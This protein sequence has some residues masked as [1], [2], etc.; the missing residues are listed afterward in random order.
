METCKIY[1]LN[2][3]KTL[4]A[5][6]LATSEE[7][8]RVASL[9]TS[10]ENFIEAVYFLGLILRHCNSDGHVCLNV[11]DM[12][13]LILDILKK[14]LLN[15]E[16][17]TKEENREL[18]EEL[19][20]FLT[21]KK[22]TKKNFFSKY[23][24]L[25]AIYNNTELSKN[26][27]LDTLLSN[28]EDPSFLEG[29]KETK[30]FEI[31]L[32]AKLNDPLFNVN[33][34]KCPIVF[35]HK[36]FYFARNFYSEYLISED[37]K[38]IKNYD[39]LTSEIPKFSDNL[40]TNDEPSK[41]LISKIIKVNNLDGS[42]GSIIK[43]NLN[44]LKS[45]ISYF[46]D[47]ENN[48]K[49]KDEINWQKN[50]VIISLLHSISVITGGPG[51][52]KTTSVAKLITILMLI[53][54]DLKI[55]LAAPT[56]K[57]ADR[58][59]KAFIG[60]IDSTIKEIFDKNEIF[61]SIKDE[62]LLKLRDINSSTLH[63]LIGVIINKNDA[64]YNKEHPLPY[65]YL[66]IDEASMIDLALMQKT[67]DSIDFNRTK[68]I[69]LGDKDQLSSVEAGAILGD[70]CSVFNFKVKEL[71]PRV[72]EKMDIDIEAL[73]YISQINDKSKLL[74]SFKT[75]KPG[76]EEIYIAPGISSLLHSYRFTSNKG[77]GLV[78]SLINSSKGE[79]LRDYL[80]KGKSKYPSDDPT[81][82]DFY[83]VDTSID[84]NLR[85]DN[86]Y[87][88]N[89]RLDK[90]FD[91]NFKG[92]KE[93]K[94]DNYFEYLNLIIDSTIKDGEKFIFNPNSSNSSLNDNE[95][96]FEV[97]KN[98]FTSFNKFR[99]LVP[100]NEGVYGVN[101]INEYIQNLM[102]EIIKQNP[103]FKGMGQD[104]DLQWLPGLPYIVTKNDNSLGIYNGDIGICHFD[105]KGNQSHRIWFENG[106]SFP[107]SLLSNIEPAFAMTIHKSQGSEFNH[108]EVI[109]SQGAQR[110]LSKEL[111]YTAVTRAKEQLTIYGE[112]DLITKGKALEGVKRFS[113]LKE[114]LYLTN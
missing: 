60:S 72:K 76:E 87:Y 107:L 100:T 50:S 110:L 58:M 85:N 51:T 37:F 12:R 101:K 114:R 38:K 31:I 43:N 28:L 53:N 69:L 23:E 6:D 27:S 71:S 34:L 13:S 62:L 20:Q 108:T 94:R 36:A 86:K 74:A 93:Q 77:I 92:K 25:K 47:V 14:D 70:I 41:D 105:E 81:I 111:I 42:F 82:V 89:I 17:Y 2:K 95:P 67:L 112:L 98:I 52:G 26:S 97:L 79:E 4:L 61:K 15:L 11:S 5:I 57:A 33:S 54:H 102:L 103:K 8:K 24:E 68:L 84:K 78:A 63:K 48:D 75:Y 66:I 45:L 56:G 30:V 55:A 109:I 90:I 35:N 64:K 106:L 7:I 83:K 16:L 59:K 73:C 113:G 32:D 22:N 29:L 19:K 44:S 96:N 18:L 80:D 39:I 21:F 40:N 3:L 65:D 46:F 9:N 104:F 88:Q 49:N 1:A 99:I 91:D 10:N